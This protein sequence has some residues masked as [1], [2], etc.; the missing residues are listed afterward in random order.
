ML[1][2]DYEPIRALGRVE[3]RL[4]SIEISLTSIRDNIKVVRAELAVTQAAVKEQQGQWQ[5]VKTCGPWVLVGLAGAFGGQIGLEQA[6]QIVA[7]LMRW[8]P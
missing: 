7:R 1:S 3:G 5:K 4:D 6:A 2:T 8:T